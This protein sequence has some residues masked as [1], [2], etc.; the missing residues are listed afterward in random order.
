MDE[1]L[2]KKIRRFLESVSNMNSEDYYSLYKIEEENYDT[3]SESLNYQ[4]EAATK[5]L[6]ELNK[7]ME[8]PP[9][10]IPP[11]DRIRIDGFRPDKN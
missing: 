4:Q 10:P 8:N 9:L 5:L 1:K 2:L 3:G 11:Q 6:V 7:E